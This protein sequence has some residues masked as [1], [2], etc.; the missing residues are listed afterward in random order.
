MA[1]SQSAQLETR[2]I[3]AD[4]LRNLEGLLA[5]EG[6]PTED[7]R[8]AGRRFFALHDAQ[9]VAVAYGG[10]EHAGGDML[11]RS[12][13]TAPAQRGAGHG[14][15]ITEWLVAEAARSGARD[16]YLLTLT[17]RDF[18]AKIGFEAIDRTAVPP[19]V[20]ASKEFSSLCPSTAIAM[21]RPL[22]AA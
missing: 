20:A 15:A 8:E 22:S 21:K 16:L 10:L 18:F 13:V 3:T 7:V 5:A 19:A 11:L 6:L 12:V 2:E 4:S 1:R 17:A 9:Q 14:R